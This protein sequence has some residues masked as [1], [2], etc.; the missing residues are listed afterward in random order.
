[1]RPARAAGWRMVSARAGWGPRSPWSAAAELRYRLPGAA[2]RRHSLMPGSSSPPRLQPRRPVGSSESEGARGPPL[3]D[4]VRTYAPVMT[5]QLPPVAWG[6]LPKPP[7]HVMTGSWLRP[8][9]PHPARPLSRLVVIP[10]QVSC[11]TRAPVGSAE[12][13]VEQTSPIRHYAAFLAGGP[14]RPGGGSGAGPGPATPIRRCCPASTVWDEPVAAAAPSGRAVVSGDGPARRPGRLV[15]AAH[16][17][18][19]ACCCG[20]CRPGI[21]AKRQAP[22]GSAAAA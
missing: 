1:M 15:G 5:A 9:T 2:P 22:A 6:G 13:P 19:A 4:D 8:R 17:R 3:L 21:R 16:V 11:P 12:C 20:R 10:W 18:C 14:E 7:Q